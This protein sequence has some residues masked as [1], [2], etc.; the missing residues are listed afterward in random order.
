MKRIAALFTLLLAFV[1][2]SGPGSLA[3]YYPAQPHMDA[4]LHHL[5][6]AREELERASPNKGG[7]REKAIKLTDDAINQVRDGIEYANHH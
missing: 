1:L 6:E 3:V 4:A 7:H 2:I 5:Q